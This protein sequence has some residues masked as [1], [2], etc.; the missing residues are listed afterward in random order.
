[1]IEI[2]ESL[3]EYIEALKDLEAIFG[4]AKPA[5]KVVKTKS[6]DETIDQFLKQMGW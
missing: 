3:Q 1:V 2:I 5:K 4:T 6:A